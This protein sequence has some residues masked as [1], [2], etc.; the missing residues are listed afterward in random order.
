MARPKKPT[1]IKELQGT[2]RKCREEENE[3]QVAQ[4]VEM[5]EAPSFLNDDGAR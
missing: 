3:M 2:I 4:V 1:K 5:P